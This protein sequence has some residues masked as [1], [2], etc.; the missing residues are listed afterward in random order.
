MPIVHT[1]PARDAGSAPTMAPALESGDRLT[2]PEF[3]R[4]YELQP[5]RFRAELIG[6]I[7]YVA[8]PKRIDHGRNTGKL[9]VLFDLYEAATP[10]VTWNLESTT[11]LDDRSEPEP[12]LSLRIL[13]ECGGN[14]RVSER[15]YLV[16]PPEL[17]IEVAHSTVA[18]DLH[19][20]KDD[21]RRTGVLEYVVFCIDEERA[22]VFDL[23]TGQERAPEADGAFRSRLFPGLWI[24]VSAVFAEHSARLRA[25]LE[26][27]LAAPERAEFLRRMTQAAA[28]PRGGG[29]A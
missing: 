10:G 8:S 20:K 27:G 5:E 7:V 17:V 12:D 25:A 22:V 13:P 29:G 14:S 28:T 2:Q 23:P 3:H 15:G 16:G 26:R 24:D 1:P 4:R 6:G 18:I 9:T 19:A 21:Y 11:I